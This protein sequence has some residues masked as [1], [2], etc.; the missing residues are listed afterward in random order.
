MG[1]ERWSGGSDGI[2]PC[3]PRVVLARWPVQTGADPLG[4]LW[5]YTPAVAASPFFSS[6][7]RAAPSH[8]P[9]PPRPPPRHARC[10]QRNQARICTFFVRGECKRGAECPYR[11]EM[12]T[13]GPLS[14][15]NIKDRYYG[16]NDP[17]AQKLLDRAANM[18]VGGVCVWVG[19]GAVRCELHAV[20][21]AAWVQGWRSWEGTEG[22]RWWVGSF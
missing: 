8:P 13:S 2:V 17:V 21:C 9:A 14:E 16:V 11:H 10:P 5:H 1:V 15:Q 4:A 22:W 3:V 18:Q 19:G 12:P 6:P 7:C 20:Q